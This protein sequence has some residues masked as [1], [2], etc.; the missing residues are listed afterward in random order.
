M[1][2]TA[3]AYERHLLFTDVKNQFIIPFTHRVEWAGRKLYFKLEFQ[4]LSNSLPDAALH[5]FTDFSHVSFHAG[6]RDQIENVL[7]FSL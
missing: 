6:L 7:F 1:T 3:H 4:G 5:C 2:L